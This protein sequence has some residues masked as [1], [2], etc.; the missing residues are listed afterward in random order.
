MDLTE[1]DF[2]IDFRS[3]R[4]V[5]EEKMHLSLNIYEYQSWNDPRLRFE[6]N[7]NIPQFL[8]DNR[9]DF[10]AWKNEIWRPNL[11]Y[12]EENDAE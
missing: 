11:A 7:E 2:D 4:S 5:V 12:T 9:I 1:I 10:S 6:D 8:K 3:V